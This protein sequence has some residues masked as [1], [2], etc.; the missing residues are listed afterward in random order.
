MNF[1]LR[2][3]SGNYSCVAENS[4]GLGVSNNVSVTVH[5]VPTCSHPKPQLISMAVHQSIDLECS[6]TSRPGN[7]TFQWRMSLPDAEEPYEVA[8]RLVLIG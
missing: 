3:D 1:C 5:Y 2:D 8:T 7:V 4:H 6:M